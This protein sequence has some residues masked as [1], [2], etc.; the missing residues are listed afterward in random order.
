MGEASHPG[1]STGQGNRR[2]RSRSQNAVGRSAGCTE[3]D[4]TM[5]TELSSTIPASS[6]AVARVQL[7][8]RAEHDPTIIENRSP[9]ECH[10]VGAGSG[11]GDERNGLRF[12][13]LRQDSPPPTVPA[14]LGHLHRSGLWGSAV[15]TVREEESDGTAVSR[16]ESLPE[17][18][19]DAMEYDLTRNDESEVTVGTAPDFG[20]D[21]ESMNDTVDGRSDVDASVEATPVEPFAVEEV[22]ERVPDVR[23]SPAI[24][25]ALMVLGQDSSPR[26]V[27]QK[28][29]SDESSPQDVPR[30]VLCGVEVSH[31]RGE[32]RAPR[33]QRSEARARVEALPLDST[34]T[35]AQAGEGWSHPEKKAAREVSE[36]RAGTLG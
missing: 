7:V 25:E 34:V 16:E 20:S 6:R 19:L 1:P 26:R 22:D 31:E 4:A 9:H 8:S 14:S 5:T 15:A 27:S 17:A 35:V 33:V 30:S 24:R 36:I 21:T 12:R 10:S 28:G 2:H 3:R 18:V 13:Q 23:I 11:R 29:H 32:S